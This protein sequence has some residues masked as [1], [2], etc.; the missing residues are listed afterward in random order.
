[1]GF[2]TAKISIETLTRPAQRTELN[3]L[4]DTGALYSIVPAAQ[5]RA[6]GV[7]VQERQEFESADGRV[8]QRD[9]GE[10]RF[11]YDGRKALSPV[12]FGETADAAVLGVVTLEV[13]GLEFDPIRKQI[14][15][16]RKI[17]YGL[18]MAS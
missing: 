10:A 2:V 9:V 12:I 3:L 13:L 14:R 5:L 11:H 1:M 18:G 7:E 4:V 15:P 16:A 6:L 17:L 8:I